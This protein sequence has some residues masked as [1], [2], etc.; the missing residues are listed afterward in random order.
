LDLLRQAK[1]LFGVSPKLIGR[2]L[3]LNF[4]LSLR[5]DPL[6]TQRKLGTPRSWL[7]AQVT[8]L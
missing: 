8:R 1:A 4:P 7:R 6:V 5:K 2:V 3:H